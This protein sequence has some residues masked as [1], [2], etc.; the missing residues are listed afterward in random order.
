[1][2]ISSVSRLSSR[3]FVFVLALRA[4][5]ET[6]GVITQLEQNLVGLR[7]KFGQGLFNEHGGHAVLAK[8]GFETAQLTLFVAERFLL[9]AQFLLAG[10]LR[11]EI[12]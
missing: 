3:F 5:A 7:F 4:K 11:V 10:A 8:S 9:V 12:D 1:M 6:H 2:M